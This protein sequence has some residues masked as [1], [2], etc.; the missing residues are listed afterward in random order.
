MSNWFKPSTSSISVNIMRWAINFLSAKPHF[1][2]F[3]LIVCPTL[4]PY[5]VQPIHTFEW[6]VSSVNRIEI[7]S[8]L[9]EFDMLETIRILSLNL[10]Y[11]IGR[12]IIAGLHERK[13]SH[14]NR[15]DIYWHEMILH[16]N[17]WFQPTQKENSLIKTFVDKNG[18]IYFTTTIYCISK[19]P[20]SS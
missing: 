11:R 4:P 18:S 20:A 6:H 15:L 14:P 1:H 8:D 16:A 2:S 19:P 9:N 3:I 5:S 7:I 10:N 17:L 12:T 13:V